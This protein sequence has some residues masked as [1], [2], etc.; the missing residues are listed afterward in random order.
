[1]Y[2]LVKSELVSEWSLFNSHRGTFF[3]GVNRDKKP[4][5]SQ[6][7]KTQHVSSCEEERK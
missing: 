2:I 1:M 6:N 4:R 3:A 7:V 5:K